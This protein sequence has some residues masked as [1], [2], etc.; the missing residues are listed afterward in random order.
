VADI[1]SMTTASSVL[2]CDVKVE[3][4]GMIHDSR[5]VCGRSSILEPIALRI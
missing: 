3:G 1:I 2:G 5:G 4:S